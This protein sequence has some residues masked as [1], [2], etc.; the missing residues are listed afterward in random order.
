MAIL[1]AKTINLASQNLAS[2]KFKGISDEI[3]RLTDAGS[4]QKAIKAQKNIQDSLE[5]QIKKH[6]KIISQI[7][8]EADARVKALERQNNTEN[9]NLDI[10]KLQLEY[11]EKLA[12][13]DMVGAAQAQLSIQS[14][15]ADRQ[16]TLAVDSIRDKE[17][18]DIK[19]QEAIIEG[20]EKRLNGSQKIIE[21][22]LT[23]ADAALKKA[24]EL[25]ATLN[26]LIAATINAA[27]G[28]IDPKQIANLQ[29]QLKKA[30]FGNI[31]KMLSSGPN[32]PF[33][34]GLRPSTSG[35]EGLGSSVLSSVI[36]N[37]KELKTSDKS[38]L[39]YFVKNK[40]KPTSEQ[41]K[42]NTDVRSTGRGVVT[43]Y[44][45]SAQQIMASGYKLTPGTIIEV[46]GVKYAIS[47]SVDRSGNVQ[48]VKKAFGGFVSGPGTGTSDSIPAMLSN[49]EY[50]INADAVKQYGVQTFNA[51]NSKKFAL[52]GYVQ[53]MPYNTGGLVNPAN[54]MYNIN[55]TLNG[56]NLDANDVARAIHREMQMREISAGRSRTI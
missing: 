34:D 32:I 36:N 41:I 28:T 1:A 45:A 14:L 13:G 53:R 24:G 8:E 44:N 22:A 31:A 25:Q 27:N 33:K 40:A 23:S 50:V 10:K 26:E 12:A 21:K 42:V 15:S 30:G 37:N 6:Q 17:A 5:A 18:A 20:L 19:A 43:T 2:G 35:I 38:L 29:D 4:S 39:E 55:V 3:K 48:L 47:G 16:K 49:G 7:K 46:D 11:Q 51:F 52:G 54:S 9:Y 56:S